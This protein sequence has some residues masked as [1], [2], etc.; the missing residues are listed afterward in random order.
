MFAV[1]GGCPFQQSHI[2]LYISSV[3]HPTKWDALPLQ[4]KYTGM[5]LA[6]LNVRKAW[7]QSS[8]SE[9]FR[10]H[11]TTWR[12]LSLYADWYQLTRLLSI[13]GVHGEDVDQIMEKLKVTQNYVY[14]VFPGFLC[15]LPHPIF[16]STALIYLNFLGTKC[17]P[18]FTQRC[19]W[20]SKSSGRLEHTILH[21]SA[22]W[23]EQLVRW[24]PRYT[25]V[26]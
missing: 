15:L 7:H 17:L 12:P 3:N 13:G 25:S 21:M 22:R 6:E 14:C 5:K 23:H 20:V 2:F 11:E 4:R 9:R 19:L 26:H 24:E 10:S 18:L 1:I 16:P 8:L